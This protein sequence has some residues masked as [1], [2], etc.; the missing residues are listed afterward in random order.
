MKD[1]GLESPLSA[2][3]RGSELHLLSPEVDLVGETLIKD[4]FENAWMKMSVSGKT[5]LLKIF[6]KCIPQS[7]IGKEAKS[8]EELIYNILCESEEEAEECGRFLADFIVCGYGNPDS[9]KGWFC[10]L[11]LEDITRIFSSAN[12]YRKIPYNSA[13]KEELSAL[14]KEIGLKKSNTVFVC[15]YNLHLD[16]ADKI[17]AELANEASDNCIWWNQFVID[18]ACEGEG[19][20]HLFFENVQLLERT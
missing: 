16:A 12:R 4:N 3:D 15:T 13:K 19:A 11:D 2:P 7:Y 14:C 1:K 6:P 18:E 5:A 17:T 8:Q 9:S 20:V 10:A